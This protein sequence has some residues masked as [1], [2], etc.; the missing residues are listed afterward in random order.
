MSKKL[1][2]KN[3]GHSQ[4]E[5]KELVKS[6]IRNQAAS[7]KNRDKTL[8]DFYNW[9]LETCE[10]VSVAPTKSQALRRFKKDFKYSPRIGECYK[11]AR[12]FSQCGV[13]KPMDTTYVEGY[14]LS[15]GILCSHAWNCYEGQYFDATIEEVLRQHGTDSDRNTQNYYIKMVEMDFPKAYHYVQ[16]AH[17]ELQVP[18]YLDLKKMP[19]KSLYRGWNIIENYALIMTAFV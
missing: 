17:R 11:N 14:L 4:S 6:F 12:N 8:F 7:I 10:V 18:H 13:S 15:G 9:Q 1:K 5:A 2:N 16:I 3:A 19:M